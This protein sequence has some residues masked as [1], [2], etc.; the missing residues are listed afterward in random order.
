MVPA[1]ECPK[2]LGSRQPPC[3]FQEPNFGGDDPNTWRSGHWSHSVEHLSRAGS[4]SPIK[5]LR[6]SPGNP[7]PIK[8]YSARCCS[9]TPRPAVYSLCGIP[10]TDLH[11]CP[12]WKLRQSAGSLA[13]IPPEAEP[14]LVKFL[15]DFPG[16]S[17]I[18]AEV[19]HPLG[20]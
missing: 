13:L 19:E 11:F 7:T 18:G 6:K 15:H 1:P 16:G 4:F 3:S 5:E 12:C 17:A 9:R 10:Q 20:P 8:E 2:R 14:S